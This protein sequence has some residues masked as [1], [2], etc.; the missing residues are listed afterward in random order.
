M[1]T[2]PTTSLE[3]VA[4]AD[5]ARQLTGWLARPQASPRAAVLVYPTIANLT[6]AVE[7]RAAMLAD[8]GYLALIADFYGE[9]VR[10]FPHAQ[11]LARSLRGN[12][13]RYRAR[14]VAALAALRTNDAAQGLPL[15]AIGYCMG[16][17][18]ALELA[19]TGADIAVVASFHGLLETQRPA[20][21]REVQARLL[22]CHG[23]RDPLAPRG[24]LAKFEDEMDVAGARYHLHIYSHAKHGFTDPGS[25]TR[26]MEALAYDPSADRQS[27][28]AMLSLFDEVFE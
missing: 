23:H 11:E 25:D 26:G 17:G 22:V 14:L 12:V 16:G 8:A 10:D 27:W 18:A 28:A 20:H 3:P 5:G 6:P 7:R 4:Y 2:T 19:R 24:E 9:P 13:A 15:A 21:P 1:S